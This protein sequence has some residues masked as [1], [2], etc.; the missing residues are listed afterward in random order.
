[1]KRSK[2]FISPSHEEGWGIAI[3]EALACGT[4]VVAYDLPVYRIFGGCIERVREGDTSAFASMVAGLLQDSRRREQLAAE[5]RLLSTRFDWESI[6]QREAQLFTEICASSGS[7]PT[8]V[9]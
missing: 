2:L 6:A 7:V 9:D 5:G 4:P 8:R 3:C 1:M